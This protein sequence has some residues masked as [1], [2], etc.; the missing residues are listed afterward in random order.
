MPWAAVSSKVILALLLALL[1]RSPREA[2]R[3]LLNVR[4]NGD[5][6]GGG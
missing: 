3:L 4:S 2:S 6:H 5:G 1:C